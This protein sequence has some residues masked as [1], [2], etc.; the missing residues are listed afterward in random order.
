MK[1]SNMQGDELARHDPES[2]WNHQE[3]EQIQMTFDEVCMKARA[4]E[5][6]NRR[7]Y[8]LVLGLL[9]LLIGKA[10][11]N[12]VLFSAP[13]VRLGW[14]SGIA[15]FLYIAL[16]WARNGPPGKVQTMSRPDSCV[17][18]LRSELKRKRERLL[19]IRWTLFLLFPGMVACW[20]GG[21][22][23]EIA[24]WFGIDAPWYTRFQESSAP[25]IAFALLLAAAWIGFGREAHQIDREIENL[26][27]R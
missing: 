1:D 19:E 27:S 17:D 16:R 3:E 23:I 7:E 14:A 2:T 5:K 26:G 11:I 8:W 10:A 24:K 22:A 4:F 9:V 13:M 12:F 25:L 21:A 18:C 15:T 6:K 20:W